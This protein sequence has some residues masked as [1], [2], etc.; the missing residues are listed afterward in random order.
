MMSTHGGATL[1]AGM[2]EGH[3]GDIWELP[4]KH[5][6]GIWEVSGGSGGHGRPG[7]GF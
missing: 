6:G 4:G 5:L 7:A 1:E 3:L 2:L